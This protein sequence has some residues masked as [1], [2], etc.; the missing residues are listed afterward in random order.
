MLGLNPLMQIQQF[1][2]VCDNR[3]H[4]KDYNQCVAQNGSDF[5][6][7]P[8]T[9]QIIYQGLHTNNVPI[10]DILDLQ[11]HDS[12]HPSFLVCRIPVKGQLNPDIWRDYLS[13]LIL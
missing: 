9:N 4:C 1:L 11:V 13:D 10:T 7:L 6:A 5:G 8:I 3:V 12:Q 2:S